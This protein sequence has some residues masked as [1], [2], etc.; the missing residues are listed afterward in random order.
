[1]SAPSSVVRSI[2]RIASS[3]AKSFDSFLIERFAS[4]SARAFERDRVDGADPRQPRLERKLETPCENRGFRHALSLAP[5]AGTG[6]W[7]GLSLGRCVG[8]ATPARIGWFARIRL[9][10]SYAR[11]TWRSFR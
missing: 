7:R 9:S 3:S 1:M 4:E 11:F 10:G 5:E 6:P 2:I 8:T